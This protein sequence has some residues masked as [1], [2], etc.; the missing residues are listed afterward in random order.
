MPKHLAYTPVLPTAE[1]GKVRHRP[2]EDGVK[3]IIH[4]PDGG[5]CGRHS[6][7]VNSVIALLDY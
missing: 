5:P 3:G 1:E 6:T 4:T 7:A 2:L